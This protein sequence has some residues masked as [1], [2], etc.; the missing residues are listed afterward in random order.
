VKK[1]FELYYD[2]DY[3]L[4]VRDMEDTWHYVA[5]PRECNGKV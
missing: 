4:S 5:E 2:F 1:A 3:D